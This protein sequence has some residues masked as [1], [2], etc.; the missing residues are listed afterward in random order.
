MIIIIDYL[1]LTGMI[2]VLLV[3]VYSALIRWLH[4]RVR[5]NRDEGPSN[6]APIKRRAIP[7]LVA[8][9][10]TGAEIVGRRTRSR[11]VTTAR[12]SS[13]ARR[14]VSRRRNDDS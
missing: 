13:F 3:A 14:S 11:L 9:R 10:H 4:T 5:T 6:A 7:G 8:Q 2:I 1:L 12:L